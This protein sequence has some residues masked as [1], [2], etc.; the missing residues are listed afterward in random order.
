MIDLLANNT[1]IIILQYINLLNQQTVHLKLTQC[2]MSILSQLIKKETKT[3][4]NTLSFYP[5]LLTELKTSRVK[6]EVEV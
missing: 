5:W 4:D 6:V 3:T 2:Y 1:I